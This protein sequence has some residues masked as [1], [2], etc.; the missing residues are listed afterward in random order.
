M[1]NYI[2]EFQNHHAYAN[3]FQNNLVELIN[4]GVKMQALFNSKVFAF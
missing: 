2:V 1:I 4:K 3:L